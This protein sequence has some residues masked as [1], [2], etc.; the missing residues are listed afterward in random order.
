MIAAQQS[1]AT[2]VDQKPRCWRC[3]RLLAEYVARPWRFTCPRCSAVNCSEGS[4]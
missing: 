2:V 3:D 1:P 4:R